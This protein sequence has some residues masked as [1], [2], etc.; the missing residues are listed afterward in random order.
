M[1]EE[2]AH[3]ATPDEGN[4]ALGA[5]LEIAGADSQPLHQAEGGEPCCHAGL[6]IGMRFDDDWTTDS[7]TQIE[8]NG[9]AQPN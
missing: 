9:F 6:D 1:A 5:L 2:S 8:V 7:R 4:A 3:C